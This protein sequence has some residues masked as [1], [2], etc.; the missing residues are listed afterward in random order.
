MMCRKY[1]NL[2][3][4]ICRWCVCCCS[5]VEHVRERNFI[6][7]VTKLTAVIIMA[8]YS[9]HC[10]ASISLSIKIAQKPYIMGSLGPKALRSESFEA[11]GFSASHPGL[12]LRVHSL[13]Y[14]RFGDPKP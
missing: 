1:T 10:C 14:E 13:F 4:Y 6:H 7:R 8:K 3:M 9:L 5:Y 2:Y 11:K 12:A